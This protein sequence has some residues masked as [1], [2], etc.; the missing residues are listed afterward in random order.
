MSIKIFA[1]LFFKIDSKNPILD[2]IIVCIYG[3]LKEHIQTLVS[4][5]QNQ[6]SIYNDIKTLILHCVQKRYLELDNPSYTTRNYICDCISILIISGI[7]YNWKSCIEELIQEAENKDNDYNFNN[8]ENEKSKNELVYICLRSIADCDTIMNFMKD[9]DT[10]DDNYWDDS[11]NFQKQKKIEIKEGLMNKSEIIF[12]YV[13]KVYKRIDI[14]EQNLKNRIMKAIID[15]IIFW[16]QLNLNILTNNSISDIAKD[17]IN[18]IINS[19]QAINPENIRIMEIV[20]E[21]INKS[22]LSSQNCKLYEYYSNLDETDIPEQII[23][24]IKNNINSEEKQGIENWLSFTL[25]N[26]EECYKSK[27]QKEE[28]IW[29][30]AKIFSSI[31]ENYIYFFFDFTNKDINLD[32]VFLWLKILISEKRKISWM[33]FSTIES[34]MIYI[35]DYFRFNSY[36]ETQKKNFTDYLMDI[37]IKVMENCSYNKLNKNDYSSLQKEILFLNNEL[38]WNNKSNNWD[39]NNSNYVMGDDDNIMIDDIDIKEYRTSAED[40]F[41]SI[42][43]IFKTGFG[44]QNYEINFLN[45][46]FGLKGS[47]DIEKNEIQLDVILLVLKSIIKC[48]DKNSSPDLILSVTNY[49]I[50]IQNSVYFKNIRIFID[51]LLVINQFIP[52]LI[53]NEEN[54]QNV[55]SILLKKCDENSENNTNSNQIL[56]NSCYT[57]I[58]HMCKELKK[59]IIHQNYFNIFLQRYNLILNSKNSINNIYLVETLIK[60]LFYSLGINNEYNGEDE[61]K[62]NNNEKQLIVCIGGIINPLLFNNLVQNNITDKMKIKYDIIKSFILYKEIFYNISLC[63]DNIKKNIYA[64]FIPNSINDLIE[65]NGNNNQK[66]NNKKIFDLFPDDIDIINPIIEF[67]SLNSKN[68][69]ENCI[70]DICLINDV[71]MTLFRSNFNFFEIIDFLSYLY[72]YTLEIMNKKNNNFN[73][74]MNQYLLNNF[75]LLVKIS[76]EQFKSNVKNED[77]FTKINLILNIIIEVFPYLNIPLTNNDNICKDVILIIKFLLDLIAYITQSKRNEIDDKLISIIINSFQAILNNDIMKIFSDKLS[78]EYKIE[79]IQ[80]ILGNIWKLLNLKDSFGFLSEKNLPSIFYELINFDIEL[81]IDA[82]YNLLA[83]AQIFNKN[84]IINIIKY[85]RVYYQNKEKIVDIFL[86]IINIVTNKKQVDC[87]EYYFNRLNIKRA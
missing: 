3:L 60:I 85:I 13:I 68:I 48:F 43:L 69:A 35:T 34:M 86:E 5:N 45:K 30:F 59:N 37:V 70:N 77:F 82:F 19:N 23:E 25:I 8:S 41:Y 42:F 58:S 1:N 29:T 52:Y 21:L 2:H 26:L 76:I 18:R 36:N 7:T 64:K 46:I 67:Y 12:Q 51:Y 31:L 54:F 22:I 24:D 28:I 10:D 16:T 72:K 15:L 6:I 32:S 57:I 78:K 55:I 49:L 9:D 14:Y 80:N 20:S 4:T 47:N 56:I 75:L 44:V 38:D 27:I 40:V 81:F 66:N 71:F 62:E 33:F 11:L 83:S 74:N 79:L 84:Y 73:D 61:I 63:D 50:N 39:N 17:I 65:I 87:L 53:L